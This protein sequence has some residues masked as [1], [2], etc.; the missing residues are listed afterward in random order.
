MPIKIKIKRKTEREHTLYRMWGIKSSARL[1]KQILSILQK[2]NAKGRLRKKQQ[3][4]Y[5]NLKIKDGGH[6]LTLKIK[7]KNSEIFKDKI[8][9]NNYFNF[10]KAIKIKRTDF[11]KH[12]CFPYPFPQFGMPNIV[13]GQ[14]DAHFPVYTIKTKERGKEKSKKKKVNIKNGKKV[15]TNCK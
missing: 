14:R 2:A 15:A 3:W 12:P 11:P 13:C 9:G 8:C 10:T 6:L 7:N 4:L 1:A 5:I